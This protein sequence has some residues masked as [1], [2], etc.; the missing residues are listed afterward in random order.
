[1]M[2]KLK[3][4]QIITNSNS[5]FRLNLNIKKFTELSQLRYQS[6][7]TGELKRI[8]LF[9]LHN[10]K[11]NT[12]NNS[13]I[14]SP[15]VNCNNCIFRKYSSDGGKWQKHENWP[16]FG[17]IANIPNAFKMLINICKLFYIRFY[18]DSSVHVKHITVGFTKALE[19]S[20]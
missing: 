6:T 5:S 12:V 14:L 8:N 16:D 2:N 11:F 20:H 9:H 10:T 1:M 13:A 19:V 15:A 4:F 7:K 18:V 3:L 17:P